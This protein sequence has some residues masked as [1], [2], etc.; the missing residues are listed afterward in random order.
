MGFSSIK[1]RNTLAMTNPIPAAKK[2][3]EKAASA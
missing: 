1:K 3:A 2:I